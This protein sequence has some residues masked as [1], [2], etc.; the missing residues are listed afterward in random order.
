MVN[1]AGFRDSTQI[2]LPREALDG[3]VDDLEAEFTVTIR[4]EGQSARIIGSPLVIKEV[5]EYLARR[6]ISTQ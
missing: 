6:G 1:A 5:T 3:I 4:D 2:L